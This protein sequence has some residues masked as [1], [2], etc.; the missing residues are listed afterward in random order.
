MSIG[1]VVA[2]VG[3]VG[4]SAFM[5]QKPKKELVTRNV[6]DKHSKKVKMSKQK[7]F[8]EGAERLFS[9]TAVR[10]A[11][12]RRENPSA[13]LEKITDQ[14]LDNWFVTETKPEK[15]NA[16]PKIKEF[17]G[18]DE[19]IQPVGEIKKYK[20]EKIEP[21]HLEN[22]KEQE[23]KKTIEKQSVDHLYDA[24][25]EFTPSSTVPEDIDWFKDTVVNAEPR[26]KQGI[27]RA[28]KRSMGLEQE[29][30]FDTSKP[31]TVEEIVHTLRKEKGFNIT[32][33]DTSLKCD[34]MDAII[35]CQGIS[36]KQIHSLADSI[37]RLAKHRYEYAHFLPPNLS[38]DGADSDDWK[39]LDLGRYM[40]HCFTEKA[41]LEMDIEG[42]WLGMEETET[43]KFDGRSTKENLRETRH[44]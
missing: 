31:I 12:R 20:M 1:R 18:P 3:T 42:I 38:I 24:R 26:W 15:L 23:P 13:E 40:V 9:T 41:R 8:G 34:H 39:M 19:P 28:A 44:K 22:I 11:R 5:L 2:A 27:K 30:E 25:H 36:T 43:K 10:F 6:S 32:V 17:T 21:E 4:L 29:K 16:K 37:R 33:I 14:L 35:I 7:K